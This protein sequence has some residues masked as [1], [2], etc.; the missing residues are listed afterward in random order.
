MTDYFE[1]ADEIYTEL[2]DNKYFT[3]DTR[4]ELHKKAENCLKM[5]KLQEKRK[6]TNAISELAN[7][8]FMLENV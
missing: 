2:R 8:I 7:A 3:E 5:A 6:R 4:R 1:L